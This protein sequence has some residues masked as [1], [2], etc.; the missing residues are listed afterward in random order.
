MKIVINT[1]FG[2][3]KLSPMAQERYTE[4]TGITPKDWDTIPRTDK[5]LVQVV[6]ELVDKANGSVCGHKV[7]QLEVV[8]IE[9]GTVYRIDEYKG[10]ESIEYRDK[11]EWS[12]A[13]DN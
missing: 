13:E 4:L 6:E 2:G 7:A 1:K 9:N 12:V 11:I 5:A 10:F 3:F 8:E